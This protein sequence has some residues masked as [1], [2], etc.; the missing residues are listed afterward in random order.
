[1]IGLVENAI[2]ARMKAASDAGVLGYKYRALESWG[3]QFADDD[4]LNKLIQ[5]PAAYVAYLGS[6]PS[7]ETGAYDQ[8]TAR[9]AVMLAS[10]NVRNEAAT[11]HGAAGEVGVYQMIIDAQGLLKRQDFGLDISGLSLGPVRPLFSGKLE[12]RRI[13]VF[14]VEFTTIY[15]D[16][17]DIDAQIEE[18]DDF[19]TFHVNW[20]LPPLG[21][22]APANELPDDE[23]AD[24]TS[25]QTFKEEEA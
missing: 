24:A 7:G 10:Q 6:T 20:D 11:R 13:S 16:A 25:T 21:N 19:S 23:N 2:L 18:L 15:S 8:Q 17:P 14:A 22:V 3:G 5:Y 12:T 1:M 9:F 4:Q